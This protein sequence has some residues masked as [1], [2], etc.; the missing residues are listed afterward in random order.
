MVKQNFDE[1]R[2]ASRARRILSIQFRLHKSRFK[3][4]D[5]RWHL[6][7]TYDMSV[8]GLSFL[9][10]VPYHVDDQLEVHVVMSG[11]LDIFQGYAK[12]VRVEK[13]ETGSF[14]LVAIKFVRNLAVCG[15]RKSVPVVKK[16]RGMIK[17]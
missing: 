3:G 14:Y 16:R 2:G 6:S 9:S 8:L 1:R 5:E 13:K 10:E 11:V 15:R 4:G 17:A 12:V 7:T